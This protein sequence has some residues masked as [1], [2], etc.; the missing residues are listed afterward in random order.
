M[1]PSL[2]PSSHSLAY[3]DICNE[4]GGLANQGSWANYWSSTGQSA[5]NAYNLN[6]NTSG[7]VNPVNYNNKYNG[8]TVRCIEK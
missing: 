6:F 1:C 5:T 3:G 7:G 4:G 2:V 8:R